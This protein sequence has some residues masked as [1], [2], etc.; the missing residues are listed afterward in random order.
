M[1]IAQ[2][3]E[4]LVGSVLGERVY[5][6]LIEPL[7]G[8]G[9]LILSMRGARLATSSFFKATWLTLKT[10]TVG[11]PVMLS[12]ATDEILEEFDVFL[13][14]YRMPGLEA[15]DWGDNEVM[16][17]RLHGQVE[18]PSLNALLALIEMPGATAPELHK[19]SE[20]GV[21][22]TAWTN[23]LNELYRNGLATR[24]KSG[25]AWRFFPA[26]RRVLHG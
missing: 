4:E 2:G 24:E 8:G 14:R 7:V 16:L 12:D 20:E 10:E 3:N 13:G 5:R 21:S 22:T 11:V 25:R 19:V 15:L 26:A 1:D 23:R 18:A 17:A 9:V 6:E